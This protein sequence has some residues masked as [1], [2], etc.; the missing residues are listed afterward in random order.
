MRCPGCFGKLENVNYK[1]VV[2]DRCDRCDGLWFDAGEL[3]AAKDRADPF[4]Q[5][6]D[7][8]LW[9]DDTKFK[10]RQ[11]RVRQ[12][13]KDGVPLYEVEYG[14]SGIAADFCNVCGGVFLDNGEF[15]AIL[16][17]LRTQLDRRTFGDLLRASVEEGKEV[18]LGQEGFLSEVSDFFVVQQLVLHRIFARLPFLA[19]LVE[20]LP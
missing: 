3:R 20:Q 8:D 4:L 7:V 16:D 5:W 13:P 18:F 1:H 19:Q 15:R 17:Y 9:A 14:D 12:C 2:L 11:G 10:L 6:M